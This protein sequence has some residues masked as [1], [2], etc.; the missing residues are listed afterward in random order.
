MFRDA[1]WAARDA[2][3]L[4]QRHW[5]ALFL[6]VGSYVMSI[7][8]NASF[9]VGLEGP[10]QRIWFWC[11]VGFGLGAVMVFRGQRATAARQGRQ[12]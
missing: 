1:S 5:A 6:F 9:D 10:M 7:V 2:H 4:G 3:R 12:P 11:L 8:I